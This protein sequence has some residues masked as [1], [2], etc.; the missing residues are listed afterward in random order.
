M[1]RF[2]EF[3]NG[4]DCVKKKQAGTSEEKVVFQYRKKRCQEKLQPETEQEPGHQPDRIR[5]LT[6]AGQLQRAIKNQGQEQQEGP[7]RIDVFV[8]DNAEQPGRAAEQ[9]AKAA[10]TQHLLQPEKPDAPV[11]SPVTKTESYPSVPALQE[12]DRPDLF[13]PFKRDEVQHYQVSLCPDNSINL[14]IESLISGYT[15]GG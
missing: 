15:R 3:P 11:L 6:R 2:L 12:Y 10:G 1:D 4:H 14:S 5:G 7:D 8:A 9:Y 13:V